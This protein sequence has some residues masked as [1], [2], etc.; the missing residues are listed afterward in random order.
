MADATAAEYQRQ[1]KKLGEVLAKQRALFEKLTDIQNEIDE[2][3]E[4][5]GGNSLR[6]RHLVHAFETA[7]AKRYG[8]NGAQYVWAMLEDAANWKRLLRKLPENELEAR[9]G[10]Y[11]AANDEYYRQQ[12]HSFRTFV[13]NVN[14]FADER[15]L[16]LVD[17]PPSDCRH[18]PR[19]SSDQEHTRRRARD[20][21]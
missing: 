21:R 14:Q 19:C 18:E 8:T 6:V 15:P 13:A 17:P 20:L 11:F 3:L 4:G 12:R 10:I 1:I 2:I 9:I 5:K 7:W 16:D